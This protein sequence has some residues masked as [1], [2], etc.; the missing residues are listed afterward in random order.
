M[1]FDALSLHM[2]QKSTVASAAVWHRLHLQ[3]KET[4]WH[5]QAMAGRDRRP[6]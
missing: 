4:S 2:P 1:A 5:A 6:S 3:V